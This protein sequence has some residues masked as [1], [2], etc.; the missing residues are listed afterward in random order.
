MRQT[1]VSEKCDFGLMKERNNSRSQKTLRQSGERGISIAELLIVVAM[2]GV[3][4][5]FA[6]MQIAGA[7]RSMRLTNSAREFMG[8]LER[9]RHDS[10]RRHPMSREEMASISIASANTYII[11]IDRNGDGALDPPLSITIPGTHGAAFAGITTPT[12]IWYNWRGRP[13]DAD[14]NLL[15][16]SFRLQDTSGNT[17]HINLTNA[18]DS[19]L[20]SSVNA[21]SVS[22]SSVSPTA[23]IKAKTTVP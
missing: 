12:I 16:L 13:V 9:A 11:R 15:N 7:Q 14:G 18:G 21:S 19:S 1:R 4:T 6:V 23:N 10:L 2:I 3:V 5:A 22:V 17:N 8:W 20:G